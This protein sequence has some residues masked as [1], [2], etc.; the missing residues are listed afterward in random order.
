M[1]TKMATKAQAVALKS[2]PDDEGTFEALVAVF[3]NIDSYGDVI[4]KGAFAD[5]LKEWGDS[6]YPVPVVWSH[7]KDDPFSH[8]GVVTEAKETETGL[9][10]KAQLDMENPKAKQVHKLLKG[11]RIKEFSF[12]FSYDME[13]VSPAKRDSVEVR[14]LKKLKLYEVGPT[15]VGAN[16]STQLMGVKS[17][18]ADDDPAPTDP[19]GDP[20]PADDDTPNDDTGGDDWAK[21]A[22]IVS[23]VSNLLTQLGDI[24][25]R[26]TTDEDDDESDPDDGDEASRSQ[27][28]DDETT[29]KSSEV[30]A[31][32]S[33]EEQKSLAALYAAILQEDSDG[34]QSSTD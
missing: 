15:M 17:V 2:A 8:I 10:V 7:D 24:I 27:T 23:E 20:A 4:L 6:G 1:T 25:T 29:G 18:K 31:D 33:A 12:A 28:D 9:V 34:S 19:A 11:G 21:A 30:S 16:P 32:R 26:N 5:T 3:N 14:E 13:D 22:E